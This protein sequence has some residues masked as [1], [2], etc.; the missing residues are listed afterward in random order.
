MEIG[1]THICRR[2]FDVRQVDECS[3]R[4]YNQCTGMKPMV[5]E[6]YFQDTDGIEEHFDNWA[7]EEVK[8]CPY[9]GIKAEE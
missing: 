5:F 7:I 2:D 4:A 6:V 8:Y 9:C 3:G 1:S